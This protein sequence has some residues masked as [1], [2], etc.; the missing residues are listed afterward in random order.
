MVEFDIVRQLQKDLCPAPLSRKSAPV[1][2]IGDDAA[3]VE[4]PPGK[5]LVVT[6]DTLVEGTHFLPETAPGDLAHKALAVNLSDL[7]AMGAEPAWFFLGLTLPSGDSDW[8]HQFSSGLQP[9]ARASGVLLA[10]GD[11]TSGP[12]S[13]TITALGLV[14]EGAALT[15]SGAQPGNLI[16]V[17]GQ[18]GD[19]ALA[20]EIQRSGGL[21]V[22]SV[23]VALDRPEPRLA[24]GAGLVGLATSCID[25]SDGFV[26]D[27]SHILRASE[28]GAEVDLGRLPHSAAL[29]SLTESRR[30]ELQ[31]NGG[32]DYEL[33]FTI[34]A[35]NEAELHRLAQASGETLTVV[36]TVTDSGR[37]LLRKP[38]GAEFTPVGSGWEHFSDSMEQSG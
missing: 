33:C 20:L 37:L 11:T 13:V 19:A 31:L 35:D 15:R 14:E 1:I 5:Q 22:D 4:V 24:V 21:P 26:A 18:L 30:W 16:V 17:S 27:L 23:H 29:S 9:L 38:D 25:I 28:V 34:P 7:A 32:D 6:T 36:G 8:V 3:V 2:G 10:G 12:L